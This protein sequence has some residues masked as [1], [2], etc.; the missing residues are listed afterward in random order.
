MLGRVIGEDIRLESVLSPSLGCVLA[1]PGQLHQVLMNLAVNARDAMPNG[2]TLLIETMNLDLDESFA[3][4][5]A[6][7]KPGR[8]RA[9]EGQ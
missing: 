9:T 1:D 5:H 7:V 3:D 4:Q 6:G 8:V 2:G